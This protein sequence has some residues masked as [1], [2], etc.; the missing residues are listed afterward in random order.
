MSEREL[1][2][3]G[4][5]HLYGIEVPAEF[6]GIVFD[7]MEQLAKDLGRFHL[8]EG[9]RDYILGQYHVVHVDAF[10]EFVRK[11]VLAKDKMELAEKLAASLDDPIDE[12]RGAEENLR[13]IADKVI[14]VLAQLEE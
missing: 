11:A 3:D 8:N 1:A 2:G 9:L 10:I 4:F 5:T 14:K 13:V 6:L 12:W 7:Q